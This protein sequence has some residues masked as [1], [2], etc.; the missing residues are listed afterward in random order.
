MNAARKANFKASFDKRYDEKALVSYGFADL[1][2]N[3]PLRCKDLK[4][5]QGRFRSHAYMISSVICTPPL[6]IIVVL[7][8]QN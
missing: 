4:R 8:P 1:L 6:S 5:G 3:V 7:L 2:L